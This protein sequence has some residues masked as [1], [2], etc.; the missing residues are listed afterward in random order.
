MRGSYSIKARQYGLWP[1]Y[2]TLMGWTSLG[3]DLVV[4][5]SSRHPRAWYAGVGGQLRMR[6]GMD[7]N[8]GRNAK[9]GYRRRL[10]PL[11]GKSTLPSSVF[12]LRSDA[13]NIF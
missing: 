3:S 4:G 12:R 8:V 13:W 5:R 9:E 11:D 7:E 1:Q 6:A 2:A 10:V